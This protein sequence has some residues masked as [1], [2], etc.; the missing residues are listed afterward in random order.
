MARTKQ[1]AKKKQQARQAQQP[2]DGGQADS[3]GEQQ[4]EGR[5]FMLAGRNGQV[6]AR[7]CA[8]T[9]LHTNY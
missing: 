4:A 9:L 2:H 7:L 1:T 8:T 3:G 5:K 6:L